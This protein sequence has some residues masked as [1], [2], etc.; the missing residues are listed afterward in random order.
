MYMKP[1]RLKRV[2]HGVCCS[3]ECNNAYKKK[4]FKGENNHQYG[5]KGPK[6]S[7]FKNTKIKTNYGYYAIYSPNHPF[8]DSGNRVK[9]HRLVVEAHY[10]LF[11]IKYFCEIDGKF[12][13]KP[14]VEVHHINEIKTDNRI[15]N[16]I[17]LTKV[18]HTRLHNNKKI[19]KRDNLGRF[20]SSK[21][22]NKE[23]I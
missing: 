16:L 15:E 2:K 3:S 18:E 19:I 9:E 11:D 10:S 6:N 21:K 13:L 7:S 17:P 8:K 23:I 14:D 20:I 12:Y 5:L 1:S 22:L 4:W